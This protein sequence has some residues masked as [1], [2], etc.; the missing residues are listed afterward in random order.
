MPAAT[1]NVKTLAI[2]C[3][4]GESFGLYKMG[5]D[6]GMMPHITIANVACGFHAS[7]PSVMAHTVRLAKQH[8]VRGRCASF[9][10][11]SSRVWPTRDEDAARGADRL[12]Y[13]SGRGA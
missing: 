3:D 1:P 10:A 2:N 7:D 6:E 13:L 4:M 5:N 8:R 12:H 11:G 9:P